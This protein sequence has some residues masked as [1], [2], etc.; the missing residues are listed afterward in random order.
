VQNLPP[1]H[2][3][4]AVSRFA[5]T[6]IQPPRLRA[7]SLIA[8]P[9][10]ET[11]LTRALRE[12][13]LVLVCAAA[14]FG[15]TSLLARQIDLLPAGTAV[16]WVGCDSDD[17][18]VQL[19]EC[20]VAALEPY[21]PPWRTDPEALIAAAALATTRE[22]RRTIVVE[23]LNALHAC[24]VEHGVIFVDDLHRVSHPMV[25]EF[26]ELL[27]E[28]F[29]P[30][31]TM[32]IATRE[33]PPIA[34]A[35]LRGAGEVAD[36]RLADL[37]FDPEETRALAA[38]AGLDAQAADM[39][40][41][42]TEG[43]PVGLRLALDLQR[44]G[45]ATAPRPAQPIDPRVFDYL[46]TEVLDRMKPE[47][48][49]FLLACSVLPELTPAR[50]AAVTGDALA[51]RHL[52]E[53]DRAGLF[54]TPLVEADPT[55]RLHD[56]FREAL[57]H[58]LRRERPLALPQLLARAAASETDPM[59][60]IGYLLQ[61]QSWEA[62]AAELL[63]QTP[64]LLTCG[65][66]GVVL[67]QLQRFP[68]ARR[69]TLPD[70]QLALGL[71]GWARW[72]WPTMQA[73]TRRAAE[74]YRRAGRALHALQAR[75][76][77]VVA[78]RGGGQHDEAVAAAAALHDDVDGVIDAQAWTS[79][80]ATG[81]EPE[82]VTLALLT[83]EGTWRAFD[84]GRLADLPA[85]V[86][87]Q[88]ALLAR[89][90]GA[91]TLY[92]S[93]PLPMVVG[94]AGMHEPMLR[95][96]QAVLA[97]TDNSP[98]ELRTL[99]RGLR[100][101]LRLWTGDVEGALPEL[102]EAAE[103]VQ[104]R[105]CP[106]RLTLYV[107]APLN[108]AHALRGDVPALRA[109]GERF[110]A[111]LRRAAELPALTQRVYFELFTLARWMLC[112]GCDDRARALLKSI[113]GRVDRG[114]RPLFTHQR[115]ALGG[116]LAWLDGD[117]V[118]ARHAFEPLLDDSA[119][120]LLGLASELRLRVAHL[121]LASGD[122]PAAV[123]PVLGPLFARHAGDADIAA[124]W[125]VGAALL[126]DLAQV[127]WG[128]AMTPGQRRQLSD[129]A[130]RA[131]ALRASGAPSRAPMTAATPRPAPDAAA[132]LSQREREVLQRLAAGDSNKLIA[133]AFDLSPHTVK[134]H[135]ANILDKLCLS[136][137]GQAAAWFRAHP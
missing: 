30:R 68:E 42:R 124:V 129:W 98:G 32:V 104:W 50:C 111:V 112:A 116:Y 83:L 126:Q 122:A 60:R 131:A 67:H 41:A 25:H 38:A 96:V 22:A 29:T 35:R 94:V 57:L 66:V 46:S 65:S 137:R 51:A 49:E 135:V 76:Y 113:Q 31:W 55:W 117:W 2:R 81:N 1:S 28:R 114:E 33:E 86:S 27:L 48:R 89:S 16:A 11:R 108:L 90:T 127:P 3:L 70:L 109:A 75:A 64:A 21:D 19:L 72:D 93:L 69:A 61:A 132:T 20:L 56:L 44:G 115:R 18:P 23:V 87:E 8:R 39:L 5:R 92:R 59:R 13:R 101:A 62:A 102:H 80:P 91:D 4:I 24:E 40:Q 52:E 121:R 130:T 53:I 14:G 106:L 10:I 34:L 123:A 105:D 107:Q 97:R 71:T 12:Q 79:V 58:C 73:A 17:S 103:E 43:W 36:L 37:R 15:K 99:A 78:L 47:L 9:A 134:R 125:C 26:L 6:K 84:E 128:D 136:S 74:G 119:K 54:V 7:G 110:E 88:M 120:G 95:Y 45:G 63:L 82:Y 85:Q 100:G 77:E 118:G 133:R